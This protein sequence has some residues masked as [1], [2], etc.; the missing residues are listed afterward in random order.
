M[1]QIILKAWEDEQE[2][3]KRKDHITDVLSS[4]SIFDTDSLWTR[5][6][7]ISP[8]V[9][10]KDTVY[11]LKLLGEKRAVE[12]VNEK[13]LSFQEM[14]FA[15]YWVLLTFLWDYLKKTKGLF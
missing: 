2:L 6:V 3:R 4:K 1:M 13:N 5:N 14:M 10:A 12:E 8:K 15:V 9:N 11:V 7:D